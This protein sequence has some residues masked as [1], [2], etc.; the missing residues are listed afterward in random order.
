MAE[1]RSVKYPD[2]TAFIISNPQ[3]IPEILNRKPSIYHIFLIDDSQVKHANVTVCRGRSSHDTAVMICQEM[4]QRRLTHIVSDEGNRPLE[5]KV[6]ELIGDS[7]KFALG[8]GIQNGLE[9]LWNNLSYLD[10]SRSIDS[11][12]GLFQGVP[13]IIIAAGPSLQ[14]NIQ[15][16][17]ELKSKALLISCG[18]ALGPLRRRWIDPHFEVVVDPNPAMYEALKP[19]LDSTACFLMSI[20]AQHRISACPVQR[21]YFLVNYYKKALE[22]IRQFTGIR[23]ILPAMASVA[24]TAL[25][26]ALHAGC[27]PIVFVGQDLCYADDR[28]HIDG[29]ALPED[30][31][32]LNALNGRSV[33]TSPAMKEAFDFYSSFIPTIKDRTIINA[34]EGGAGIPGAV[35]LT[36]AET[37]A[38]YFLQP[39]SFP[40][41]P[42]LSLDE[43]KMEARL[44]ELRNSLNAMHV[45]ASGFQRKIQAQLDAGRD[46]AGTGA[47]I[48]AW[49]ESL[50]TLAGYEYLA[51]Y[52][53]W[54]FYTADTMNGLESKVELLQSTS[55]ILQQQIYLI[56]KTIRS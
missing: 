44:K 41:L 12:R 7:C 13:G 16:L 2:R 50:R 43:E 21:M 18:S 5:Q 30:A 3:L 14:K 33:R 34:T 55:Q 52:L 49:F 36:L 32:I 4:L 46:I 47:K 22:D 31:C 28:T 19:C 25:F 23:T 37:A 9:N 24:T 53:D 11:T 17:N 10:G 29:N 20:M 26:F 35:S 45:K 54:A 1:T 8:G 38:R 27:D 51:G 39:I 6:S 48:S 40:D 42:P 15:M 56:T